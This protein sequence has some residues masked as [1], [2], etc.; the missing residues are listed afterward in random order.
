MQN[1]LKVLEAEPLPNKEEEQDQCRRP[2]ADPE[3]PTV[4]QLSLAFNV[5][6]DISHVG[7]GWVLWCAPGL[8][9]W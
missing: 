5:D 4:V 8:I 9:C 2:L 7:T 1:C 6:E 3:A